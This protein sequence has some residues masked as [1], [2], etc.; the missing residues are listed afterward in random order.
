RP[1][2]ARSARPTSR[3]CTRTGSGRRCRRTADVPRRWVFKRKRDGTLWVALL[4]PE[5]ELLQWILKDVRELVATPN[6][7][8]PVVDRLYPRAYLDPTEESAETQ[9]Q[10]LVHDDLVQARLDAVDAMLATLGRASENSD[11]SL[12]V[13]LSADE[14]A[15]WLT[16]LND[17]RLAV[18]TRA[19]VSE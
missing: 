9:W 11:G 2:R 3:A 17:A 14:E 16:V 19:E 1:G 13:A 18:G 15:Q 6:A 10:E 4:A 12:R 8:D 7:G 5:V